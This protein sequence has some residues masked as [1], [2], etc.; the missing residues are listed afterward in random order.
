ME[1]L[2][3][4]LA[5]SEKKNI[6]RTTCIYIYIIYIKK[7]CNNRNNLDDRLADDTCGNRLIGLLIIL[8]SQVISKYIYMY[9]IFLLQLLPDI[10][11]FK[12]LN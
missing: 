3:L 4:V 12:Y 9:I 11:I 1:D 7:K 10:L 5:I 8:V 6:Q 2:Y